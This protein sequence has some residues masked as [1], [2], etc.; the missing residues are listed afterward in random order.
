MLEQGVGLRYIQTILG[1]SS[2]KAT[3]I[4]THVSK[5]FLRNIKSPFD[6]IF[7]KKVSNDNG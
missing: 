5:Y 7:D 1:H 6:A 4:Y 2:P 3:E